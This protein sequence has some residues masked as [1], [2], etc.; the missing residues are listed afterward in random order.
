M[1]T[2]TKVMPKSSAKP[3]LI[4][5]SIAMDWLDTMIINRR[6]TQAV[7]DAIARD[8]KAGHWRVNG[9]P[10]RF[11][12][13]GRLIDGQHRL[14]AIVEANKSV[15]SYVVTDIHP[16]A[17]ST[18]DTG[19]RRTFSNHL[20]ISGDSTY[21]TCV[22][23]MARLLWVD[24]YTTKALEAGRISPTHQELMAV[25]RANPTLVDSASATAT[26]PFLAAHSVLAFAH[27]KMSCLNR[28]AANEWAYLL[29]TGEG[30]TKNHPILHLRNRFI[31]SRQSLTH[32]FTR[33]EVLGLCYK[34]WNFMRN[35]KT[36]RNL[37]FWNTEELPT[38]Q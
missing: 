23:A 16:T 27:F 24:A 32:R 6:I 33:R 2:R 22:A 18:I 12:L 21:S 38:L 29:T 5:P 36:C 30:L 37:R 14:W 31:K 26:T 34:S 8:I 28:K 20:E 10:I 17:M 3:T 15:L 7:I 35:G 25:C 13:K 4:T 19:K 11:D 9:D 1:A